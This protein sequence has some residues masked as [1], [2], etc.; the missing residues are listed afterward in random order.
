MQSTI[1]DL[2]SEGSLN[3]PVQSYDVDSFYEVG[4]LVM[5][6]RKEPYPES[7]FC[8]VYKAVNDNDEDTYSLGGRGKES[9]SGKDITDYAI[10]Q[11]IAYH[12]ST[13]KRLDKAQAFAEIVQDRYPLDRTSPS[14][15][16]IRDLAKQHGVEGEIGLWPLSESTAK[17]LCF[18]YN[19]KRK[20]AISLL[21]SDV[22]DG[23]ST[24][25]L[26]PNC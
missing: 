12:P 14:L 6:M 11:T 21:D 24:A 23:V 5:S 1:E 18:L 3:F 10:C 8:P 17:T 22:P 9:K 16:D 7:F 4:D 19:P 2:R 26:D 13:D 20:A 25:L 15:Q